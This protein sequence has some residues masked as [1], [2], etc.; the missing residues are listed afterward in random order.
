MRKRE[1][2]AYII[3][4]AIATVLF[5]V[6]TKPKLTIADVSVASDTAVVADTVPIFRVS[7]YDSICRYHRVGLEDACCGG[8]C[9]VEV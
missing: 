9:G 6:N 2:I 1:K 5:I 8:L 7:A 4:V 3:G